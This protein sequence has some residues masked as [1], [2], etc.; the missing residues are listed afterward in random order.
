MNEQTRDRHS[1]N[2]Y[3]CGEEG[4]EREWTTH[5]DPYNGGDGGVICPNC[6]GSEVTKGMYEFTVTL[7]GYGS[8]PTE[9]WEDVC[10]SLA[11]DYGTTPD[12]DLWTFSKED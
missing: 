7:A 6:L 12:D 9:A 5:A 11:N 3:F 2:C 1:V 10:D 8:T 4:D